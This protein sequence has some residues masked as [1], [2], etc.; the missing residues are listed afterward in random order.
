VCLTAPQ[1]IS[2]TSF[3]TLKLMHNEGGTLVDRTTTRNF[4][5][6][7]VCGVVNSL[8]P[9]ATAE[10][11]DPQK[12][13]IAGLIRDSLGIPIGEASITLSGAEART[14]ISD[15]NGL[16]AFMNL[17]AGAPFTVEVRKLGFLFSPPLQDVINL[18][19]DV[20][21][22]FVGSAASF[23]ISG[24][25]SKM[26]NERVTMA[27]TGD[28]SREIVVDNNGKYAFT[29]VPA[30]GTYVISPS[31]E[32]VAFSPLQTVIVDL[33]QDETDVDFSAISGNNPPAADSI[34]PQLQCVVDNRNGTFT[35]H[36]G[37]LNENNFLVSIPIGSSNKFNPAPHDRGQPTTFQ[38][39]RVENAFSVE[40]KGTKLTWKLKGPDH[41]RNTAIATKE[42]PRC[43]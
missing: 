40:F 22:L 9:F 18:S 32:E 35:A 20:N 24:R 6:R 14:S 42:S 2:Q 33:D 39:G 10:A 16:F 23:T 5:T 34:V 41:H 21:L 31:A 11:I 37:Y 7:T 1:G 8:S 19:S 3:D 29:G 12:P 28:A 15:Q 30:A 43:P 17:P 4:A 27:L 38:P 26:K 36:F 25:V 13:S